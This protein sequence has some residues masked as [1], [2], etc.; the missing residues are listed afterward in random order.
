VTAAERLRRIV[1]ALRAAA[2]RLE[3]PVVGRIRRETADPFR[4]LVS[5]IISLRT[6]D[7]VTAA[8]SRR[9]FALA[10]TPRALAGLSARRIARAIYPAAFYR[11]KGRHLRAL[12]A[13]LLERHGGRVPRAEADLLALDGVGRKT[14]NLVRGEGFGI[15]A[16]CVDVH[17][18]RISNR[19]GLV[20]TRT[21]EETEAALRRILPRRLWTRWNGWLVPFGQHVCRPVSPWCSRC[22][23]RRLCPRRGVGRSR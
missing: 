23:L 14:A 21:P 8:A 18:H 12:A 13:A 16:I 5:C 9:L 2:R 4:V 22:P 10:A 11:V 6:K 20:R 15:P 19:L 17:V 1:P 3:T 7:A